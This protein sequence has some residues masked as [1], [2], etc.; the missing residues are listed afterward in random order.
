M[1]K[2]IV[3]SLVTGILASTGVAR[4]KSADKPSGEILFYSERGGKGQLFLLDFEGGGVRPVGRSG[5]RPDHYPQWSPNG[6]RILFESYRTGGWHSWGMDP[7]GKNP[8]RISDFPGG[9]TQHYEFDASFAPDNQTII[10]I[11]NFDLYEVSSKDRTPRRLGPATPALY[12]SAPSFAPNGNR[13][14]FSGY[15]STD[16][17]VHLYTVDAKGENRQQLTSGKGWSLAPTWSP[18]GAKILF[19]SDREGSLELYELDS[20]GGVPRPVLQ[21]D[22][23]K[24]AGFGSTKRI[25]PWDNDN[26]AVWQYRASYSPDGE[27]IAFSRQ[28]E[29]DRE[30]FISNRQGTEIRRI[31]HHKGHDGMPAW[32]PSEQN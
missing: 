27:W 21:P 18:D 12:E 11:N 29:G 30:L 4:A 1:R 19:Y 20:K 32:R 31:T 3:I 13:I 9:S 22:A 17:T 28:V 5:S 24:E 6:Q 8:R 14:V 10:F 2:F 16:E 23:I 7:D 25:D 26:G 15:Q